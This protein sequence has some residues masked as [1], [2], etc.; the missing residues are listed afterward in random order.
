[1]VIVYTGWRRPIGCLSLQVFATKEP[2]IIGLFCGK[3]PVKM[4]HPMGLRH[5]VANA[6]ASWL[7]FFLLERSHVK[8]RNK[9]EILKSQLAAN[10]KTKLYMEWL[11]SWLLRI[12][13]SW[14]RQ[15][16]W[17]FSKVSSTVISWSK[18]SGELTFENFYLLPVPQVWPYRRS[19]DENSQKSVPSSFYIVNWVASWLLRISA[20]YK[21][22]SVRSMRERARILKKSARYW[23]W[24]VKRL[25]IRLLRIFTLWKI[26]AGSVRERARILK[27]QLATDFAM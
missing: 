15:Y 22:E 26:K 14:W 1:M 20:L 3:W 11:Y 23:I 2:L 6:V 27:N 4:I 13:T 9:N 7:F 12:T 19:T 21:I 17:N 5:P 18:F 10:S 24:C 8:N 25:Q 16:W